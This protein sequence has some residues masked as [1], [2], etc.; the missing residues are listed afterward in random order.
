M[1]RAAI[2]EDLNIIYAIET[3]CFDSDIISR[4]SL[5]YMILNPHSH[6]LVYTHYKVIVGYILTL[7]PKRSVLGRHYSLAVLPEYRGAGIARKLLKA[8]E[9]RCSGKL[10]FKLEIRKNNLIAEKLYESLGYVAHRL[11]EQ[12]YEDGEDAIEMVKIA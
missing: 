11:K 6:L 7:C 12:Y 8:A 5:R 1:I 9:S 4:R 2:L 3:A 10:G